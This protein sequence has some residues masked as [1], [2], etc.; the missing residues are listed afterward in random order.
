M[1][2]A[3]EVSEETPY[4]VR[5]GGPTCLAGDIIGD[6]AFSLPLNPGDKLLFCDMALYTMVK[7]NTFNGMPL[8]S[9]VHYDGETLE[10]IRSFGYD[11]FKMRLG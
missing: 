1:A 7:T 6:Y 3:E 8:P 5:L 9:I 2:G 10:Q 4:R 11:D